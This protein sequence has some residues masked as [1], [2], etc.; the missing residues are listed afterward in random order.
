MI[1]GIRMCTVNSDASYD[2]L[3]KTGGYAFWIIC[4]VTDDKP[5]I[6]KNYGK[7]R[8]NITD[9]NE[10][11]IKC[12]V[13][14]LHTIYQYRNEFEWLIINCDNQTVANIGSTGKV[15]SKFELEGK[16]LLRLLECFRN[17]KFK[18]IKGHT[19]IDSP[20]HY[21]NRWCD[22]YAKEYRNKL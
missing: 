13:N 17:V 3:T 21:I 12:V 20:R 18:P 11:E 6:I 22:K 9:S 15:P 8:N 1:N 4:D 7:F 5:V 14:A 16:E 19:S 10:A 2:P